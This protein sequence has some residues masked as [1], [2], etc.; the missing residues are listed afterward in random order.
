MPTTTRETKYHANREE[1][2]PDGGL[3]EDV[4]PEDRVDGCVARL[5]CELLVM[6]MCTRCVECEDGKNE[7]AVSVPAH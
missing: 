5:L 7:H 3:E 2:A 4:D 1:D 6:F